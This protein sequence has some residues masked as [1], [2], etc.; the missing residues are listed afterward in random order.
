MQASDEEQCLYR[1]TRYRERMVQD[2]TRAYGQLRSIL[3]ELCPDYLNTEGMCPL[4]SATTLAV[5]SQ[6][7]G[8]EGLQRASVR[9]I[10]ECVSQAS[11]GRYREALARR[12]KAVAASI[13]WPKSLRKVFTQELT[14]CVEAIKRCIQKVSAVEAELTRLVDAH[15]AGPSL[16][17]IPGHGL[18]TVATLLGEWAP[19]ARVATKAG[20]ATY[21]GVT[22]VSRESGKGKGHCKKAQNVNKRVL[23]ALFKGA[24]ASLRTSDMDRR[25]YQRKRAD[26]AGH[27][28]PHIAAV[29][30][31]ARQRHKLVYRLFHTGENYDPERLQKSTERRQRGLSPL[32]VTSVGLRPPSVT[33]NTAR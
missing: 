14:H 10:T 2:R 22:P 4:K 26:Y 12:L 17:S 19:L 27:P 21:G 8:L 1:L 20:C 29:L 9:K 25:Y 23:N 33:P 6:W 18:I 11:R 31:L 15:P 30:A 7:P 3:V 28:F 32:G 5:L 16:L 13:T 24:M